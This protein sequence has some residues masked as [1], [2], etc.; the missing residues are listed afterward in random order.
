MNNINIEN[1]FFYSI[2]ISIS[3]PIL[4]YLFNIDKKK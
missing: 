2:M 3:I 1:N 4:I